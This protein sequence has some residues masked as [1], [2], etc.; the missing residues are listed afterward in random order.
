MQRQQIDLKMNKTKLWML[1]IAGLLLVSCSVNDNVVTPSGN[2]SAPF[3][4]K[5]NG[6]KYS[7]DPTTTDTLEL[8]SLSTEF[9]AQ[10]NVSNPDRYDWIKVNGITLEFTIATNHCLRNTATQ[11]KAPDGGT[12]RNMYL[13]AMCIIAITPTTP[14]SW[15]GASAATIPACA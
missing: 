5:L 2:D 11:Q 15:I 3:S 10:I 13:M 8:L 9:D 4:F 12:S 6:L 7:I 1:S 14:T